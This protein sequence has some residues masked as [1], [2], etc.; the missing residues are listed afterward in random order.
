MVRRMSWRGRRGERGAK[1]AAS[2]LAGAT[3][4][5]VSGTDDAASAIRRAVARIELERPVRRLGIAA[6][7]DPAAAQA[8]A[9]ALAAERDAVAGTV[10]GI[11]AGGFDA[12]VAV[13]LASLPAPALV[14]EVGVL[15]DSLI[16][17][18]LLSDAGPGER[19]EAPAPSHD[20]ALEALAALER[21]AGSHESQPAPP[22][23]APTPV[24]GE[25]LAALERAA[26][27]AGPAPSPDAER[28]RRRE[29][30]LER[31]LADLERRESAFRKVSQV[32]AR[33]G[34]VGGPQA[35]PAAELA[36]ANERAARAE[37]RAAEL[38][39]RVRVLQG[40]VEELEAAA[41]GERSAGATSAASSMA[42]TWGAPTMARLE[43]VVAEAFDRG[44]PEAEEWSF[45]LPLLRDRADA[46]GR[47]PPEL[48]SLVE[49]V[50][51]RALSA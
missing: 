49:S 15:G 2:A 28:L 32:V 7:G 22:P 44:L 24:P 30:E 21:A 19:E 31:R 35:A 51:G 16:G 20:D 17:V 29:A 10:E 38:E 33:R 46:Q 3:L 26:S 50:F 25:A 8:V 37:A 27:S 14:Q 40:R 6:V 18:V 36:A 42:G 4:A 47:L 1:E 9:A 41:R 23:V 34:A 13:A 43:R 5:R 11:A 39:E 48:D 45:Y 12:V